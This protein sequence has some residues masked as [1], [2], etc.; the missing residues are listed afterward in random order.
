MS[1]L[2]KNIDTIAIVFLMTFLISDFLTSVAYKLM[3][4]SF[5]RYSGAI[6]LVF[7]VL[8]VGMIITNFK[9]S[10]RTFWF[11]LAFTISFIISQFLLNEP[12]AYDF[13]TQLLSGNIYFF[14]R[15][16][17]LLIFILFIKTVLLKE[18]TYEKI[19]RYF[20]YFLYIN[21]IALL[22]GYLF[23]VEIFRSY[24]YTTRFGVSGFF[25]KPG[26]ASYMY[27]IAVIV[28]YYFWIE[29]KSK[30]DFYKL[31]FFIACSLCLGQKKMLLF[32]GLLGVVHLIHYNRFK[33]VFRILLPVSLAVF[34]FFKESIIQAVL[35]RSPFWKVIY[36]ESG[37]MSAIFS[38]RDQ[39]FVNA[40]THIEENWTFLN[41]IFGGLDFNHFKVE[42]EFIDLYIFLGVSGI[43][44]YLYVVSSC[45]NGGNFLKRNLIVITFLSSLLS[46]GLI[47]NVTAAI[48]LY[49][50]AKYIMLPNNPSED[51]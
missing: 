12:G 32:L 41:Y 16:I 49:I 50:A 36:E 19:Y 1:Y 48:F 9:K 43:V 31:L 8:M 23:H 42:F 17:Y 38:Y 11:I 20:E 22:V 21:A 39:L 35:S 29:K 44:Y 37:L 2:K 46:G 7:E 34:L 10:I 15:Y 24:E 30:K 4:N 47:L 5:Y 33:K 14:N 6:K 25:S 28:S 27:M 18:E 13:K 45:L 3:P 51:R 40:I 26:E